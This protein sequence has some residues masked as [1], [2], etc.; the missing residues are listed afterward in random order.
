MKSE[1]HI[2]N[3]G[4]T[5][6]FGG[7]GVGDIHAIYI[8]I[9]DEWAYAHM[10][11]IRSTVQQFNIYNYIK[12]NELKDEKKNIVTAPAYPISIHLTPNTP[13]TMYNI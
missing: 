10:K 3:S 11:W 7:G 9:S 8:F 4:A 5:V 12:K 2:A 13:C 1:T 6:F